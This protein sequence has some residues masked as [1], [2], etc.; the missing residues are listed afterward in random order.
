[1][2]GSGLTHVDERGSAR[3]V[4]VAA[5]DVTVRTAMATGLL[6]VSAEVITLLRGPG[7][8]K[9]D[10]LGTARIAGIMAAKR[11][12]DLVPLCHPIALSG[13]T[14]ELTVHDDA[15]E[16]VA[17]VRTADRTGVEMEALT[18]V[19]VAALTL[20]DMVKAV[21]PGAQLSEVRVLSKSGGRTG[22]WQAAAP[23][24]RGA[25]PHSHP[26]SAPR[27]PLGA[28]GHRA[29]AASTSRLPA[30]AR[31]RV[32]TVSDRAHRGVYQDRSGPLL[33]DGLAALGFQVDPP[34]VV[35]DERADIETALRAAIAD[36]VELVVTTGGTGLGARD[37]TPE[38]T[39]TVL[40]RPV[41]GLAEALRAAGRDTV[42][43]AALSRGLVGTAGDT[44]VVNLPG[45][46][47]GVRDG[48]AVLADVVV[49]A[50]AQLGG[51]DD[52][53][54]RYGAEPAG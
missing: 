53:P 7:V 26:D 33:A 5:K 44:L 3:M 37:V 6:L 45:S 32:V 31:A 38:A 36:G 12:P 23:R 43:A 40:E 10:A 39:A 11:T 51:Q 50:V 22:D 4:D 49:H 25:A 34:T 19:T 42:P 2:T 15:V 1:M 30:G 16:I 29:G 48:L 46:T 21:D 9:G 24:H 14:V 54:R 52:H 8:A 27:P 47:G 28:A 17:T 13:V 41:P 20:H 35:P 18:A